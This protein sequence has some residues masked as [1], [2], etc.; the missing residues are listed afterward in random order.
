MSIINFFNNFR[1]SKYIRL[2][3][4]FKEEKTQQVSTAVITVILVFLFGIFAMLPT[5]SSI[6]QL[7]QEEN[8]DQA[9]KLQLQQKIDNLSV[10]QQK[11]NSLNNDF[12]YILAAIPQKTDMPLL[13]AQLQS[14]GKASNVSF[15]S[16]QTNQ[17]TGDNTNVTN[18]PPKTNNYF[19]I[20]FSATGTY[21]DILNFLSNTLKMQRIIT[22]DN[23]SIN[24]NTENV[25][26]L[27]FSVRGKAYFEP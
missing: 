25:S 20:S 13:E 19:Y 17:T 12:P 16:L 2:L 9:L 15:T 7:Q 23:I 1:K 3:P 24:K 27:Q 14:L 8:N 5:I 11:Y 22:L 10:L 26:Q 6:M 4:N 18:L 21:S